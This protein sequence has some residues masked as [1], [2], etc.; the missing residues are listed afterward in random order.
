MDRQG[1]ERRGEFRLDTRMA[2]KTRVRL[3]RFFLPGRLSQACSLLYI[4]RPAVTFPPLFRRSHLSFEYGSARSRK[5]DETQPHA[6]LVNWL[7]FVIRA[8]ISVMYPRQP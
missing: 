6:S 1:G 5:Q 3:I 2:P 4:I 7:V 8:L